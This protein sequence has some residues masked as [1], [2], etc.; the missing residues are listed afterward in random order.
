VPFS[1]RELKPDDFGTIDYLY[2]SHIHPDHSHPDT[3]K[4]L[5]DSVRQ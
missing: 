3:L 1:P 2:T 5:P 4:A